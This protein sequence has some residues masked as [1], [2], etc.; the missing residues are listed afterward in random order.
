MVH[1]G[2][3]GRRQMLWVCSNLRGGDGS[4]PPGAPVQRGRGWVLVV[5]GVTEDTD[6]QGGWKRGGRRGKGGPGPSVAHHSRRREG[7]REAGD[8][9]AADP[10]AE[11]PHNWEHTLPGTAGRQD[12]C[13]GQRGGCSTC[14]WGEP[15]ST[16]PQYTSAFLTFILLLMDVVEIRKH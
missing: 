13:L 9:S 5:V 8:E 12:C 1:R 2:L 10:G 3:C 11:V 7:L 14:A 4:P 6:A 16:L 15:S